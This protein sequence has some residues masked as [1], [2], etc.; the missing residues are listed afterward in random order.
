MRED[1]KFMPEDLGISSSE[2]LRFIKTLDGYKMHTHSLLMARG[3]SIFSES[4]YTLITIKRYKERIPF[5]KV[6]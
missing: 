4:Y 6:S 3:D 2:V 1:K 5:Q